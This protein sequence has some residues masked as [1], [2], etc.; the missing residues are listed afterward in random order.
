M[1]LIIATLHDSV[2]EAISRR[3]MSR[4]FKVTVIA[5]TSGW[6]HKGMKT[7]LI[8]ADDEKVQDALSIIRQNCSRPPESKERCATIFI[9]KVHEF[10]HF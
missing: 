2:E 3:L 8:G 7:L 1:K 9:L 6:L 5:S 4:H 10:V